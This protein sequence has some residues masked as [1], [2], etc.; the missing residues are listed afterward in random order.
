MIRQTH[1]SITNVSEHT[2]NDT[3]T[4]AKGVTLSEECG[5]GLQGS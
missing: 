3:W 4:E 2:I 5:L 1:T